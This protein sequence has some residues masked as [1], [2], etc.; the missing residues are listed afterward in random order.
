MMEMKMYVLNDIAANIM[1]YDSVTWNMYKKDE[2]RYLKLNNVLI[3][4]PPDPTIMNYECTYRIID[5][6][7]T[8]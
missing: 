4:G 3:V 2:S 8:D 7:F 1:K 5:R 6:I